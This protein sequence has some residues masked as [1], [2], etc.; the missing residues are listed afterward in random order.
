MDMRCGLSGHCVLDTSQVIVQQHAEYHNRIS[1]NFMEFE[2]EIAE[3][4]QHSI[5]L[6]SQISAINSKRPRNR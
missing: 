3:L 1:V 4:D 6:E 5:G 2:R